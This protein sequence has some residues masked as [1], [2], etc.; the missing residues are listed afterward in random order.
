MV[1]GEG[2]IYQLLAALLLFFN[3]PNYDFDSA[4]IVTD[5]AFE[6]YK[7]RYVYEV[8]PLNPVIESKMQADDGRTLETVT[9]DA[10]Y[11]I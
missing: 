4:P 11:P 5:E 3:L 10:A 7:E 1:V 8:T 2:L 9:I 6:I